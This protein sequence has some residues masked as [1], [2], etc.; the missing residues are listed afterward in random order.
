MRIFVPG[1]EG[2]YNSRGQEASHLRSGSLGH[3]NFDLSN[4]NGCE[5]GLW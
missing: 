1:L 4:R 2:R 5:S 3:D